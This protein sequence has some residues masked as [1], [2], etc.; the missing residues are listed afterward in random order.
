MGTRG[1]VE[2]AD[3]G[4]AP[5]VPTLVGVTTGRHEGFDRA[6]FEF[7]RRLPGY[8]IEYIEPPL[9]ADGSGLP[10]DIAGSAFLQVRFSVA[11]AHDDAG[12]VTI[13]A[14]ELKPGLPSMVELEQTGDFE[15]YVTWVIGLP[16]ELDFRFA[17]LEDPFRVV[18]DIAQPSP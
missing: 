13:E 8:R 6:V 9:T 11:Q 16:E 15:G 7:E 2:K 12:N 3:T 4:T 18:I 14:R 10:V 1:P 5:P 17:D